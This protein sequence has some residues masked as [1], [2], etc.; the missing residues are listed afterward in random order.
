MDE[1][2]LSDPE[3]SQDRS[4]RGGPALL[5]DMDGV[6][7]FELRPGRAIGYRSLVSEAVGEIELRFRNE[8]G[9]PHITS[10]PGRPV[11]PGPQCRS[12]R[13]TVLPGLFASS[14]VETVDF[15][16]SSSLHPP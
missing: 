6:V 15:G 8:V 7:T 14:A 12:Y 9:P 10:R 4:C 2:G 3:K 1:L 11:G 5:A 16:D 13:R